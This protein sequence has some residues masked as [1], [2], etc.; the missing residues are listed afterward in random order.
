M[1]ATIAIRDAVSIDTTESPA[2][3]SLATAATIRKIAGPGM[4]NHAPTLLV[5]TATN[6]PP[7][8][9][10]TTAAKSTISDTA[11]VVSHPAWRRTT[12]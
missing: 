4:G 3:T 12:R 9:M 1:R 5:A 6:S 2:K 10:R 11:R 7:A 8:T